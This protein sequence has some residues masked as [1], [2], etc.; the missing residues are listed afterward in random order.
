[1]SQQEGT[2]A[3]AY[4][5]LIT[6]ARAAGYTHHVYGSRLSGQQHVWM[7][8]KAMW[9]SWMGGEVE[10]SNEAGTMLHLRDGDAPNPVLV[11]ELA[12]ALGLLPRETRALAGPLAELQAE[13]DR[14]AAGIRAAACTCDWYDGR[15]LADCPARYAPRLAYHAEVTR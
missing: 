10:L 15:H 11:A 7:H 8:G 1:M 2:K 9:L 5:A 6:R 13:V 14:L 3:L 4:R 12:E